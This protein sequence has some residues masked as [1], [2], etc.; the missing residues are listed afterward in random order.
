MGQNFFWNFFEKIFF[1][2]NQP[3]KEF[4]AKKIFSKNFK[5]I[6]WYKKIFWKIL[7]CEKTPSLSQKMMI[8]HKKYMSGLY[9]NLFEKSEIF[10]LLSLRDR[11]LLTICVRIPCRRKIHSNWHNNNFKIDTSLPNTVYIIIGVLPGQFWLPVYGFGRA[12]ARWNRLGLKTMDQWK[13][14]ASRA[15]RARSARKCVFLLHK[16]P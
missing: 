13:I 11:L 7:I 3:K 2:I 5:K 6:F 12:I 9:E 1:A 15:P 4:K 14:F 8:Y 10:V 16:P